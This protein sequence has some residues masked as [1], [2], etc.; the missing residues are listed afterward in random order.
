MGAGC[1]APLIQTVFIFTP[2]SVRDNRGQIL[3]V[4]AERFYED[5]CKG[6]HCFLCGI[7]PREAEF[8][9]EHVIPKWLLKKYTLHD[10]TIT[11]PNFTDIRYS[12]YK[13]PCCSR[14][15]Q[16]LGRKVE[17]PI[18]ELMELGFEYV[19]RYINE[20]G[21]WPIF[22]WLALIF[23]KLHIKDLSLK[24]SLQSPS[25][26]G[27]I[28]DMH[29]WPSLHHVHCIARMPYTGVGAEPEVLG[30]FLMFRAKLENRVEM[31]DFRSYTASK[32]MS[33]TLGDMFF[34]VCLDDAGMVRQC[35]QSRLSRISGPL[36]P[37]QRREMLALFGYT[38]L[39]LKQLP[40]FRTMID[41]AVGQVTIASDVPRYVQA[42]ENDQLWGDILDTVCGDILD[43][44][45]QPDI[46]EVRGHIRRGE[47]SFLVDGN[48]HFI[49][50]EA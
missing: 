20:H 49:E 13:V 17:Q 4:N 10:R 9:D 36:S 12:Q 14:C 15:N 48:G 16:L 8:T 2:D 32:T 3:F 6:G 40:T 31:F 19:A 30:S 28:G 27:R 21:P 26:S 47:W 34:V 29:D 22:V 1:S 11:L 37:L 24:M 5:I 46:E 44:I 41:S 35:R 42:V 33:L 38:R 7:G 25:D 23:I 18:R 50:S 43:R 45:D 39:V